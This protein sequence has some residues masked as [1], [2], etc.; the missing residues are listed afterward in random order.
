M[1]KYSFNVIVWLARLTI[2]WDS[3]TRDGPDSAT[4]SSNK[5]NDGRSEDADAADSLAEE[6]PWGS[7]KL[8]VAFLPTQKKLQNFYRHAK[9]PDDIIQKH[10]PETH[11]CPMHSDSN[12]TTVT[13]LSGNSKNS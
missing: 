2:S 4:K 10:L 1:L 7:D 5:S 3:R 6:G 13:C 9:H 12:T 11:I 8:T